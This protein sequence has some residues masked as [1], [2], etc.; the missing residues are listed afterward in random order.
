MF[1]H[2]YNLARVDRANQQLYLDR[3]AGSRNN[4][5][6][7]KKLDDLFTSMQLDPAQRKRMLTELFDLSRDSVEVKAKDGT[8]YT[9]PLKKLIVD[10]ERAAESVT[11]EMRHALP[12]V[13]IAT[14]G[15]QLDAEYLQKLTKTTDKEFSLPAADGKQ[16]TLFPGHYVEVTDT[17]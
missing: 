11:D 10:R 16:I 12:L 7:M 9:V 14:A 3:F 13:F 5:P 6:E 8:A 15:Q 1:K 4:S 2:K 17:Q